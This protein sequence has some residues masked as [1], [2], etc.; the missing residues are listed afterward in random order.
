MG[1]YVNPT[2]GRTKEEFLNQEAEKGPIK[3]NTFEELSKDDC[4]PVVLV[5]NYHFTAAGV[6]YSK[7]EFVVFTDPHDPRP[8]KIFKVKIDK[9]LP[10]SDLEDYL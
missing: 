6:A 3:S 8:R 10:H 5:N 4:L 1:C 7:Q 2:D 9:L